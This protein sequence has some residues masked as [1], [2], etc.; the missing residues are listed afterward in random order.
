[1]NPWILAIRPKTLAAGI[2]PV[3]IG[4]AIAYG[5]GLFHLPS[6]LACLTGALLIQIATN[7]SNDY[8]DFKKGAD[9]NRIGPA[10]VTQA[11][12]IKSQL[13]LFTA[14]LAFVLAGLI[15]LYLIDRAGM[16]IAIIA[17]A[18]IISGLL[19]TAGPRPLGYLGL[20]EL[21]VFIFFGPVAVGATYFVQT[22]DLNWAVV[23][24][25]FAPGFLSCAILAVN[26]LRD[27]DGDRRAGKMTLAVRWGRSFAISE[28]LFCLMAASFVP[29]LV[30]LIT[31]DHEGIILAAVVSFLAIPTIRTVMTTLDPHALTHALAQT[32][33]WL[34]LYSIIFSLGWILCSR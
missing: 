10:R 24:A 8:F 16:S 7:L 18:A 2:T 32:S 21:F 11:G 29:V 9:A 3:I 15:S 14:L 26:N 4:S 30:F 6:A 1:M 34:F 28:Y 12:L 22:L 25:G 33:R 27:I 20:G 5:D 23:I 19:Y 17:A 13:V 31:A